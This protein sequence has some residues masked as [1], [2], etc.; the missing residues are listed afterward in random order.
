M[1][2]AFE[3]LPKMLNTALID[4]ENARLTLVQ[5]LE[6]NRTGHSWTR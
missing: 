3:L 5:H 1:I 2:E 4:V 6:E